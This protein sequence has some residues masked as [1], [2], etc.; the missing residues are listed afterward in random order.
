MGRRSGALTA[1]KQT[2]A[3]L[4]FLSSR[5]SMAAGGRG[6]GEPAGEEARSDI[7][8]GIRGNL[9]CLC[10]RASQG[11]NTARFVCACARVS[12]PELFLSAQKECVQL[13]AGGKAEVATQVLPSI[14]SREQPTVETRS[15]ASAWRSLSGG[16]RSRSSVQDERRHLKSE[17]RHGVWVC[18]SRRDLRVGLSQVKSGFRP[19]FFEIVDPRH[20]AKY[21][22]IAAGGFSGFLV[23]RALAL[24][25]LF[26]PCCDVTSISRP[27]W[28][29]ALSASG[30]R[31]CR[32]TT[33]IE[34]HRMV[35]GCARDRA[36]APSL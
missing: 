30:L 24:G 26:L 5:C 7:V 1:K 23:R 8:V 34:A 9:A 31:R 28:E 21:A 32:P 11:A 27:F 29:A 19:L 33:R 10:V 14:A 17:S 25:G 35:R 20:L 6:R 22:G 36:F 2:R 12:S 18:I 16:G 15:G 4:A 13:Q 3:R